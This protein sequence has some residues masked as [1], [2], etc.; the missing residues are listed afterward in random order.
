MVDLVYFSYFLLLS[1]F[2]LFQSIEF[3][4]LGPLYCNDFQ[5]F[6]QLFDFN[7]T[8]NI[9]IENGTFIIN[10]I[11]IDCEL[12]RFTDAILFCIEFNIEFYS[13][14]TAEMFIIRAFFSKI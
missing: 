1:K 6:K 12:M 4:S 7:S 5:L 11:F 8:S 3:L 13:T 14:L 2:I 10:E 9:Q